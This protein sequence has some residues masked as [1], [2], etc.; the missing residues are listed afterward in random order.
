MN[1][2]SNQGLRGFTHQLSEETG[3]KA[4]QHY[5]QQKEDRQEG[6]NDAIRFAADYSVRCS[7]P[8]IIMKLLAPVRKRLRIDLYLLSACCVIL[9]AYALVLKILPT[10]DK[11]FIISL[12][13]ILPVLIALAVSYVNVFRLAQECSKNLQNSKW[14]KEDFEKYSGDSSQQQ[15]GDGSAS[16]ESSRKGSRGSAAGSTGSRGRSTKRAQESSSASGASSSTRSKQSRSKS[17]QSG[18]SRPSQGGKA[19][20]DSRKN[21]K[22]HQS[23]DSNGGSSGMGADSRQADTNRGEHT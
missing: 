16:R 1:G 10:S 22:S 3:E 21:G 6:T 18:S 2:K 11:V 7:V 4:C 19:S 23:N 14:L 8:F 12:C 15:A 20:S 17:S 5:E 9:A 13:F